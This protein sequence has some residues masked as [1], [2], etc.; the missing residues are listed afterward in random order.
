MHR[1]LIIAG[2]D[3]SG[4]AGI[5][6]DIK[7]VTCLGAY[8]MTAITALT[9]QNTQ[10]VTG[11]M[12][13]P[14]ETILA[15]GLACLDDIGADTVKTGMLGDVAVMET[16]AQLMDA[17]EAF[18]VVDPVMVA[19]G[20]HP[21]LAQ[22]AVAALKSIMV[23]RA[24]LLTPNSPEAAALTGFAVDNEGDARRAG[25]ALLKA[26]ARNVLIKGGH[27]PGP[28][29]VDL[30]FTQ[31]QVFRFASERIDTPHTHGT[32]CT[33][34]SAC[35]ALWRPDRPLQDRV[36]LARDYVLGAILMAP[37]LGHGHGPLRHNWLL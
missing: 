11:V 36:T 33:L 9:I 35:A 32:G 15:Q 4:G 31:D 2:S 24:G 27:L 19:K 7:T 6:A 37:G 25:E 14:P 17:T 16:V 22:E 23:P 8:A 30:L 29:V 1:V 10:G 18:A 12:A 5:Q 28:E 34:A 13:V 21:L 20:G 26:G 3:P